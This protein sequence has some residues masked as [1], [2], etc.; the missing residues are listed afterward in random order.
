M[1][2]AGIVL[3][4][5]YDSALLLYADEVLFSKPLQRWG[6]AFGEGATWRGRFLAF[7]VLM[8]PGAP[9]LRA[10]WGGDRT[11]SERVAVEHMLR[12]LRPLR[13][14]AWPVALGLFGLVPLALIRHWPPTWVLGLLLLIYLP[15]VLAV[16]VLWLRREQLGL[17]GKAVA[18]IAFDVLACP[19]FA[20]NLVRRVTLRSELAMPASAF[21]ET[22]LD[23]QS[24][25]RLQQQWQ[26]R[27]ALLDDT[28][29]GG[30]R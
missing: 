5:L 23:A 6:A 18:A 27:C 29:S 21:A 26:I 4:Y 1:L 12:T 28:N 25:A 10:T 14:L 16:M 17:S 8:C 24:L 20:L 30:P 13:W 7:P 15:T 11:P 19:P 3:F 22:V 9:L 2:L